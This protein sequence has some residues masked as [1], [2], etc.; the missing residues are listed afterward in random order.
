MG[1]TPLT[2]PIHSAGKSL[3]LVGQTETVI[4]HR[5]TG[6]VG[7]QDPTVHHELNVNVSGLGCDFSF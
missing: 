1:Y 2:P 5:D 4:F 6:A 7:Q 3:A